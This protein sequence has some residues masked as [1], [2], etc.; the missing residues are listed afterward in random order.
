[1]SDSETILR[2][3]QPE[4]PILIEDISNMFPERSRY[5]VDNTLK[6]M[7]ASGQMKRFS[8]GVYYIPER[9][10]L[11]NDCI[12]AE[13]VIEKKYIKDD[14]DVY[15]Y[16][17]GPSLLYA[18]NIIDRKPDRITIVSNKEKSRG[19]MVMVGNQRLYISKAPTKVDRYNYL[20][21]KLLEAIKLTVNSDNESAKQRIY[22]Y[23]R[24]NRIK[25]SEVSKYCKHF[26]DSV[27]K[28]ILS[29][30]LL[31]LLIH[32]EKRNLNGW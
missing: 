17:S 29:S 22:E 3:F 24:V 31:Q 5:W 18:M 25:I 14:D 32:N 7:I 20:T 26:P 8:T 27:S 13:R 23:S 1:M 10:S 16:F 4:E 28:T 15:G 21:L 30:R 6:A 12:S 11:L 9:G 19:R 2:I